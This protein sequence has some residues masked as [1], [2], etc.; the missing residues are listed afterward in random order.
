MN[1]EIF[2]VAIFFILMAIAQFSIMYFVVHAKKEHKPIKFY[3]NGYAILYYP[4][5]NKYVATYPNGDDEIDNEI[6]YSYEDAIRF[7]DNMTKH[8]RITN[9]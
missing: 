3:H 5:T 2:V 6:F 8:E 4:Q 9:P 7:I 1:T